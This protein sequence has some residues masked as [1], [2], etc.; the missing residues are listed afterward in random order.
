MSAYYIYGICIL[1]VFVLIALLW[2]RR[3]SSKKAKDA[4]KS[5][6]FVSEKHLYDIIRVRYP[7]AVSNRYHPASDPR[8]AAGLR[9]AAHSIYIPSKKTAIEY[10]G[11]QHY[12][13]VD[14]FG[15]RKQYR[16]QRKLDKKKKRLCRRHKIRLLY[17][18]Y[19]QDAPNRLHWKKIYKSEKE[20]FRK[21]RWM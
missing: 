14:I 1:A 3:K 9:I 5:L 10:Q 15:G 11:E 13:P 12:R 7:N 17:F 4:H 8:Q 19:R 20:L 2:R 21:L 6:R 18:S 16:R